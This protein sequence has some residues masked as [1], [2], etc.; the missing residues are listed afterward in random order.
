[1]KGRRGWCVWLA[2]LGSAS[3]LRAGEEPGSDPVG[4]TREVPPLAELIAR[5]K[6]DQPSAVRVEAARA[7]GRLGEEGRPAAHALY[8]ASRGRDDEVF[9]A[10]LEALCRLGAPEG[11]ER[12]RQELTLNGYK[13]KRQP[14]D[15]ESIRDAVAPQLIEL[16]LDAH[17]QEA[18]LDQLGPR[19]VE[20]IAALRRGLD[21]RKW[22]TRQAAATGLRYLGPAA[23]PA[24]PQLLRALE[25][26]NP[27]VCILAASAVCQIE[28]RPEAVSVLAAGLRRTESGVRSVAAAYLAEIGADAG[29]ATADLVE[30][31]D[32]PVP[33][34]RDYA[35]TALKN[36]GRRAHPDLL[37]GLRPGSARRRRLA[38]SLLSET[39]APPETAEALRAALEGSDCTFRVQAVRLLAELEPA[40]RGE[41]PPLL[42]PALRDPEAAAAAADLLGELGPDSCVVLPDLQALLS[43]PDREEALAAAAA[44]SA[45]APERAEEV[46]PVV[47]A[48]LRSGNDRLHPPALA[49]MRHL[50][51]A[52]HA[53]R[54]DLLALLAEQ[55][56][57]SGYGDGQE[58]VEAL[59]K[60]GAGA[61]ALPLLIQALRGDNERAA[62]WAQLCLFRLGNEAAPALR[63]V[64]EGDNPAAAERAR[65]VLRS[66]V[67]NSCRGVVVILRNEPDPEHEDSSP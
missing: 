6:E 54:R 64:A 28:R 27:G 43:A 30:A 7:L 24:L 46:L 16:T 19:K 12:L 58:A 50:G 17:T 21:A 51:L 4:A 52:A 15:L 18:A 13:V 9:L 11:L 34:I 25:D 29:P 53:T 47:R 23:R 59:A 2:L 66:F 67:R 36:V 8:Q 5:L 40:R 57:G 55:V 61:E 38:L 33:G 48:A 10:A 14:R 3:V 49:C 62:G 1:M 42:L 32:D 41:L 35:V 60:I 45:V 20:A 65:T 44:L 56:F 22:E 37:A 26:P 31:L 39:G 63:A